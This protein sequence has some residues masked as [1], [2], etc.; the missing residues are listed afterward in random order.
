[1]KLGCSTL[2]YGQY[3]TSEVLDGVKKAGYDAIELCAIPGMGL[4]IE[5]GKSEAEYRA[6]RQQIEDYG[7]I[8]ESIGA[9]GNDMSDKTADPS[10]KNRGPGESFLQLME[11]A[12][13]V[14]APAMTT[15]SGGKSDDPDDMKMVIETFNMMAEYCHQFGVKISVKPHVGGAVYD[16]ASALEFMSQVDTDAIGLNVDPS[17]LWRN[18]VW[19][20]GEDAIPKLAPYLC[21]A[22][23]RDTLSH[24]QSIGPV[25]TQIPG[26]GAMDLKAIMDAYKKVPGLE[27]VTVEIVGTAGWEFEKMQEVAEK[28]HAALRPLC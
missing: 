13:I 19:E 25:D 23:I 6:L 14:G 17:H 26:G 15:G 1:M 16:T 27:I 28:S 24:E 8:V 5:P 22:R 11:A 10:V 3:S 21:T 18:P 12:A 2:L 20:A 4:H 7:L 9:S